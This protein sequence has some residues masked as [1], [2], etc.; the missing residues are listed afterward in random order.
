MS[1]SIDIKDNIAFISINNPPVNALSHAVRQG[2]SEA[3]AS[4]EAN[5]D[6]QAVVL[7]CCGSTFIAGADIREFGKPAIAPHLPDV[8]RQ[9]GRAQKPWIAAIHGAALGGGL[10]IALACRY[11]IATAQAKL[12][13][14]EVQIG[15]IPGAGGTGMLPRVVDPVIALDMIAEGKPITA[16]KAF[17]VG[18]V[19]QLTDD[20]ITHAALEFALQKRADTARPSVFD[21]MP[22]AISEMQTFNDLA[23]KIE[24]RA[25]GQIAPKDAIRLI[26]NAVKTDIEQHLNDER[27]T[28]LKLKDSDQAHAL[29]HIF[30]AERATT[31]HPRVTKTQ[32]RALDHIGVV[33]GGT[34][35][36]GI[37]AACLLAG[38]SVTMV[39]RDHAAALAGAERVETIL[40]QSKSRG[41]ITSDTLTSLLASFLATSQ[42]AA[43]ATAD[44][45]IEAVFEDMDV[46][47]A[48][49]SELDAATKPSAVLASNTSYLDVNEI[50][51]SVSDPSRVVGLHFFSPA[52]I[53]KLLEIIVPD[54]VADDVMATSI[55]LAKRLGKIPVLSGVCDGFIANRIMSAYRR[56]CD[57]MLEDGA[58]PWDI[59][60]AMVAYGFPMG[61]Y[62]MQD[63]A[64][65]DIAWAMRKRVSAHRSS[66]ERYVRIADLLCEMGRFGRKT[67]QGWY[68][69]D[70]SIGRPDPAV[71]ALIIDE[72]KQK[73]ISRRPLTAPQIMD[74]I[75]D[76]MHSETD[77]ILEQGIAAK[78]EDI[79][80]VMVNA[81]GFPRW[82]GGPAYQSRLK[83]R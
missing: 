53:M 82:K 28:F 33:G 37:A 9:I 52:H 69:Y 60:A 29:R 78:P 62:Q 7:Y 20:T 50:A 12:G 26:K 46:K 65:L 45:V 67:G 36:A 61:I 81:F 35:G 57:Y 30:F 79:D 19:D 13:F 48:V 51:N 5:Q 70:G 23:A 10:E 31:K 40:Q 2:L 72:S 42:Y 8:V 64:G 44:L 38:F 1:V 73:G 55:H 34:M 32:P 76:R 80:V 18:L 59:D 6:V 24:N 77:Q 66:D 4:T 15:V 21:L 68:L 43:L 17:E 83:S 11:R 71:D 47:K 22:K 58:L 3:V 54:S 56:E 16:Q 39:E 27:E 74:R 25:K 75:L 41:L 49:F 14:P 63:L